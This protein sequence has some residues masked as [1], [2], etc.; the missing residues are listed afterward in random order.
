MGDVSLWAEHPGLYKSRE[1]KLSSSVSALDCVCDVPS[2]SPQWLTVVWHRE[3]NVPLSL[4]LLFQGILS[5]QQDMNPRHYLLMLEPVCKES[6]Q[7]YD[8]FCSAIVSPRIRP[9]LMATA[10]PSS[11]ST[12][13]DIPKILAKPP[14]LKSHGWAQQSLDSHFHT[15]GLFASFLP[16]FLLSSLT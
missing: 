13:P 12:P 9:T 15:A 5:Q 1:S 4:K 2:S 8:Y 3:P 10:C 6:I 14:L 7:F 16:S 11:P